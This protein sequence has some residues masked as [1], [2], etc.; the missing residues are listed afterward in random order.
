[1]GHAGSKPDAEN[2]LRLDAAC[3]A[4][5]RALHHSLERTLNL[6]PCIAQGPAWLPCLRRKSFM[7]SSLAGS[8]GSHAWPRG[9]C[10]HF[11]METFTRANIQK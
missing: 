5:F 2:C 10:T 8:Q 3:H 9:E 11:G 1:M 7:G 6:L 4:V